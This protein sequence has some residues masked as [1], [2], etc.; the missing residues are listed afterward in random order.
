MALQSNPY[1]LWQ[2]IPGI[3]LF[4]IGLYIQS[5]LIKKRESDVFSIF[6]FAGAI[7]AL[8]SAIQLISPSYEWQKAWNNIAYIGILIVPTAWFIGNFHCIG[9]VDHTDD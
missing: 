4:W 7:W 3:I 8:A 2:L 6:M 5:R 9:E 1:I